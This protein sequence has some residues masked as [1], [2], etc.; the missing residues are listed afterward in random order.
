MPTATLEEYLESIYRL[1]DAGPAVRPTQIA[2]SIGVSGPTVTATLRRL[3]SQGF[4]VREG[5]SVVLTPVGRER[6]LDILRRHRVAESF[7]VDTL[8]L[9]WDDAHEEACLLEHALSPRVV[10]ALEV[11]LGNPSLCPHGQPIPAADGSVSVGESGERLSE[12]ALGATVSVL[13]VSAGSEHMLGYLGVLGLRPGARVT[14]VE[15]APFAGPLTIEVQGLR[16]A[17]AREVAA[18][19][20]VALI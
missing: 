10:D 9:E 5:T 8:G 17:I 6:A 7:L 16:T 2:E 1:S 13:R 20:T 18:L 11:F 3:E 15:A 12:V 14:V 19:V 4:I